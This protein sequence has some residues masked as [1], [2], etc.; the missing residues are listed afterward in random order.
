MYNVIL[1]AKIVQLYT[2][3][4]VGILLVW[5]SAFAKLENVCLSVIYYKDMTKLK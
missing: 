5:Q 1:R 3:D 2:T 4:T